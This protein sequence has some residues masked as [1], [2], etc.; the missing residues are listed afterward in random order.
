MRRFT[1]FAL[2]MALGCAL[3]A[4][5][6]RRGARSSEALDQ[7]ATT[8][9]AT[10]WPEVVDR[11]LQLRWELAPGH[12]TALGV[13]G[14][15]KRLPRYGGRDLKRAV[16]RLTQVVQQLYAIEP[17]ALSW[18]EQVDRQLLI[19]DLRLSLHGLVEEGRPLFSPLEPIEETIEGL[20]AL[21]LSDSGALDDRLSALAE[22][23]LQLPELLTA[24]REN[25]H[26][27]AERSCRAAIA[28]AAELRAF[29]DG[30]LRLLGDRAERE[31]RDRLALGID[32]ALRGIDTFS[33]GLEPRCADAPEMRPIGAANYQTR[34]R[35]AHGVAMSADEVAAIAE[36]WLRRT[37][38]ALGHIE[39]LPKVATAA[40]PASFDRR[41]ALDVVTRQVGTL[42]SLVDERRLATLPPTAVPLR[43]VEA[44]ALLS[45]G[46]GPLALW[47]A[48]AFGRGSALLQVGLLPTG[49]IGRAA[50]SRLQQQLNSNA[51]VLLTA[52]ETFPGR[53]LQEDA[54]RRQ[55]SA[56][57]RTA[58]AAS[59]RDGWALYAVQLAIDHG[60][61]AGDAVAQRAVLEA[62]QR[63][64]ARAL[65]DARL[66]TGAFGFDQAVEFLVANT[67]AAP[68]DP[69][70]RRAAMERE[71]IGMLQAPTNAAAALI[72]KQALDELRDR[73]RAYKGNAFV[74]RR[75]HDAVLAQGAIPPAYIASILFKDPLPA[76]DPFPAHRSGA[77]SAVDEAPTQIAPRLEQ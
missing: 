30:D 73:A 8:G 51:F 60:L 61:V 44:V 9:V 5:P 2:L 58:R 47:S 50:R 10:D 54:A 34:M 38:D 67:A 22:R 62:Y 65:V 6:L 26:Q 56:I 59:L 49:K 31:L 64:A 25:L 20:V 19:A 4:C 33:N 46:Q 28:R 42:W 18:L 68:A 39:P 23:L 52:A 57:R 11:A 66:H 7:P 17:A 45:P 14:Y 12:A 72:G 3:A 35:F 55:A 29:V 63:A 76:L 48:P 71:V 37:E 69:R 53:Q 70:P 41:S 1:K 24:V 40:A 43:A 27:P 21:Y 13:R 77:E 36:E 32:E 74:L 15:D 75:F 16:D